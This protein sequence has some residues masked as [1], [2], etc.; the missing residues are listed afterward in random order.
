MKGDGMGYQDD[1]FVGKTI[2]HY[3]ILDAI[4]QGG[5]ATVFRA[6]QA[7]VN[8]IVAL[9][10]LPPQWMQ[11]P[12]FYE[13][14]QRE[15]DIIAHLEHPHIVPT[16][17]Y[18]KDNSVPYI[19]M[20]LVDGGSLA[21]RLERGPLSP[22]DLEKP[23][24]Q[25]AHALTYAHQHGIVH[26]DIKP[27]NILL[28][29]NGNAYLSDFG[30]AQVADSKLTGSNFVGTPAYMSPEQANGTTVDARSDI[31]AL[32]IVIF[33][34]LTGR[35]PFEADTPVGVLVK[36]SHEPIPSARSF[37]PGLP[38][39]IEE[40]IMKATA[41]HP[42]ERYPSAEALSDAYQLARHPKV[43]PIAEPG[44]FVLPREKPANAPRSAKNAT[45]AQRNRERMLDKVRTF[46]VQ[47]VLENSLHNAALVELGMVERP[48]AV[49]HPWGV[50]LQQPEHPDHPLPAGTHMIDVFDEMRGE[51]LILGEP[52]SGKTTMLLELTRDLFDRAQADGD[53]PM[54]VVFN[55][56]SWA[57]S[58][59]PL[60]SWLADELNRQYQVP[61]K[62]AKAWVEQDQVL[63][64]LDGLDEVRQEQR[65]ACVE[66]INAFRSEHNLL[67][68]VV[69]SRIADYE[70]L[71]KRL[72]LH[73][74]VFLQPLTIQQI[75]RYL[76]E[77]PD[78]LSPVRSALENDT[79]LVALLK[80]PLMLSIVTLAYQDM[81]D[82]LAFMAGTPNER[83]SL[84]FDTYIAHMLRRKGAAQ[85]Y[86][87]VQTTR[88]LAWLAAKQRKASQTV[89]YIE[90]M[91]PSAF[92]ET[93]MQRFLFA[94]TLGLLSFVSMSLVSIGVFGHG[95]YRLADFLFLAPI[96]LSLLLFVWLSFGRR[97][98][99]EQDMPRRGRLP[100]TVRG[101]LF[102][103]GRG[104]LIGVLGGLLYLLQDVLSY[105]SGIWDRIE[106]IGALVGFAAVSG[107]S[108][109]MTYGI[110]DGL[111][112]RRRYYRECDIRVADTVQ[113]SWRAHLRA[114]LTGLVAGSLAGMIGLYI[115]GLFS[116]LGHWG[117]DTPFGL[118]ARL[119]SALY[120]AVL[121]LPA[122]GV[123]GI[124]TAAV[125]GGAVSGEV[126]MRSR[127][128]QGMWR[129]ARNAIRSGLIRGAIFGVPVTVIHDLAIGKFE[130]LAALLLVTTLA[131][132]I[133]LL[134]GGMGVIKHVIMRLELAANGHLPLNLARFLDY[135][136]SI[137]FLRKV[138]GGY[139]FV[140]R[141][142]LEHFAAKAPEAQKVKNSAA[143]QQSLEE[144]M[145]I[146]S[147][148]PASEPV[149]SRTTPDMIS[150]ASSTQ[151]P[152]HEAVTAIGVAP[153][154][155]SESAGLH[156]LT[157][158]EMDVLRLLAKGQT[159]RQIAQVLV[160][161]EETVKTH[162]A[163]IL[164]KFHLMHRSQAAL[165]AVKRGLIS[166]DEVAV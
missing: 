63:P 90:N 104:F 122:G 19:V 2:G 55:L 117:M 154:G 156:D 71:T 88:W 161:G 30:I 105:P 134:Y 40:V 83:R 16:Y 73:D 116:L 99:S 79:A 62:V 130:P 112:S 65:T 165:Y 144:V 81:P 58:C 1:H 67:P 66:A 8:R 106:I 7:S 85:P 48:D 37:V 145:P 119:L 100:F 114:L 96:C 44:T 3:E 107:A 140:H 102:G 146:I 164:G 135:A 139:V 136:A 108:F 39:G 45:Q 160:I 82:K 60:E 69:C 123:A 103:L 23:L 70:A 50:V 150:P 17:D 51:L 118:G 64:L 5:M 166:L 129:T 56:S 87:P 68:L 132:A 120:S 22:A 78:D 47:G 162:V 12:T 149:L 94:L 36:H 24:S 121:G 76:A 143:K 28:D 11:D 59:K 38:A 89:I 86:T 20:R 158:R 53:H 52:G 141:L 159:N 155:I 80:T 26:R 151:Q 10:I 4:G 101:L 93:G 34:C 57:D 137:I 157:A 77:A 49:E 97:D 126:D 91:Q 13:R 9:K 72:R 98:T 6:R 35:K 18:G 110:L 46:W 152:S 27:G 113:W 61:T 75:D 147:T 74:A 84:I 41:K 92:L 148:L 14:F 15:V 128:N 124:A 33:E 142:L 25:V 21:Q 133:G 32:G 115:F 43:Q 127:P 42:E 111:T 31:Y 131:S 54:P 109:G 125:L 153:K 29:K 95:F 163:N 138:G